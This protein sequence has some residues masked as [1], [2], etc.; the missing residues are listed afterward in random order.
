MRKRG[1]EID[2]LITGSSPAA[3]AAIVG[4]SM[5]MTTATSESAWA[6]QDKSPGLFQVAVISTG[7]PYS[8]LVNPEIKRRSPICAASRSDRRRCAAAPTPPPCACC[9]TRTV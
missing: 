2:L 6:A 9:S 7:Y 4:G 5:H 1:V 8:L 3:I